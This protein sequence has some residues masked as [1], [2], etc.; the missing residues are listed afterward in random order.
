VRILPG[1]TVD[2]ALGR[3]RGLVAGRYT[4]RIELDQADLTAKVSRSVRIKRG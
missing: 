3:T 4:A 2:V 1:K